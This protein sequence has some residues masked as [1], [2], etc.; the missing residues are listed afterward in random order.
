MDKRSRR[1]RRFFII[2]LAASLASLIAVFVYS[3]STQREDLF[4]SLDKLGFTVFLV[5]IALHVGAL[6][7]WS[8]RLYMLADG[9]GYPVPWTACIEGV[10]ASVFAAALTPARIGGEPVRFAV[11]NTRGVPPRESSLIVLLERGLD[12]LLFILLGIWAAV[13]LIPLLPQSAILAF[14]VPA[15]LAFLILLI[16]LPLLVL[17]KPSAVLPVMQLAERMV[18]TE[19]LEKAKR[20]LVLEMARMRRALATVLA[21]K[22]SRF[23][24]AVLFTAGSWILEFSV[25]FYLLVAFGHDVPFLFVALG[26]VLV[27]LLTTLPLLPGGSGVAEVGVLGVFT[28]VAPGLTATFVLV[29]RATT[30][31]FDT[32]VGGVFALRFAGAETM[33]VLGNGD[34]AG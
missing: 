25:L 30:Y 26:S 22:P 7:L 18:G 24:L 31:Y 32:L 2:S 34:D 6:L 15:G 10:F 16:V 19:R 23:P 9:A 21:R 33:R 20:W 17:F 29:W 13:E 4:A 12:T 5:A 27:V 1:L 3:F 14:V 8:F 11:L 28:P